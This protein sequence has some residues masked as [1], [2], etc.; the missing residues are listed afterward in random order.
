MKQVIFST[1]FIKKKNPVHARKDISQDM[2]GYINE[3]LQSMT[4]NM[5]NA[6]IFHDGLDEDFITSHSNDYVSFHKVPPISN[7]ACDARWIVYRNAIEEYKTDY[8]FAT[9][10]SDVVMGG[11]P[12]HVD[13]P[14]K[15]GIL[16][17]GD[18]SN[19]YKHPWIQKR[20]E[21]LKDVLPEVYV[22]IKENPEN[23]ILNPGIIGGCYETMKE[24]FS[25][26]AD[27]VERGGPI[28]KTIDMSYH[29]YVVRNHFDG[30]YQHGE[31]VNS[32]FGKY[33]KNRK[34]VWFIHK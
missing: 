18:E 12:F 1:L 3:W 13:S 19:R 5:V 30:R 32:K 24:Y 8:V 16:Y 28:E 11:N 31:P 4:E 29:N 17:T 20:N 14:L 6:V 2:S 22:H 26:M 25:C 7:N 21:D 23:K 33:Q 15:S 27:L 34:D 10:I 9:D